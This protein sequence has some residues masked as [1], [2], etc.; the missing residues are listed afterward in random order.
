MTKQIK[1]NSDIEDSADD[2]A[3][4]ELEQ[5]LTALVRRGDAKNI[6]T[7]QGREER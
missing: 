6:D 2:L 5:A 3:D 7:T 4:F 1:L